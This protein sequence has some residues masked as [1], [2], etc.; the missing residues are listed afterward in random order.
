MNSEMRAVH[1]DCSRFR[2]IESETAMAVPPC[3][4]ASLPLKAYGSE[5]AAAELTGESISMEQSKI[6]GMQTFLHSGDFGIQEKSL[7]IG[8]K[9]P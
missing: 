7:V 8:N 5:S 3:V 1:L 6:P 4:K 2:R 9:S